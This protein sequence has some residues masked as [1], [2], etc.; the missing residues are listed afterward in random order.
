MISEHSLTV[1]WKER[2]LGD[3]REDRGGCREGSAREGACEE[4]HQRNRSC[5]WLLRGNPL[6]ALRE[7]GGSVPR[8]ARRTRP[9]VRRSRGG[10]AGAGRAGHGARDAR[11]GG[12]QCARLLRGDRAHGRLDL[13]G[14]GAFGPPPRGDPREGSGAPDGE[15]G[16]GGLPGRRE[17]S[18][19]GARGRRSGSRG[20]DAP[21]G[22]LPAGV[23]PELPRGGRARGG[24]TGLRGGDRAYLAAKLVAERR[25]KAGVA[26][27]HRSPIMAFFSPENYTADVE[28]VVSRTRGVENEPR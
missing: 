23:L 27:D 21:R 18:G 13:L 7:Q 10:A 22:V 26:N 15:R 17:A 12:K 8:C 9:Y 20:G 19:A 2:I 5:G 3:T 6:Q 28:G 11:G 24:G 16:A 1:K 25:V 14:A 4:H